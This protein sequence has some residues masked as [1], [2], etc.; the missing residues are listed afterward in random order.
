VKAAELYRRLADAW[1]NDERAPDALLA[2]A[3]NLDTSGDHKGARSVLAVLVEK[4]P[5]SDAAKQ[6]KAKLKKK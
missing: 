2:R 5:A 6:A 4:Y 1:P 3:E